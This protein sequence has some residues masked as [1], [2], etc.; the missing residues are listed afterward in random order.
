MNT[1]EQKAFVDAYDDNI[2]HVSS[3]T[4]TEIA[5]LYESGQDLSHFIGYEVSSV[6][7]ALGM[8]HSAIYWNLTKE[9][10]VTA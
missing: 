2:G 5:K 8:W 1:N 6:L 7:D 9:K 4:V 3:E 10:E